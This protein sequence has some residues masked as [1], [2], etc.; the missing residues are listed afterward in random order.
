MAEEA[1]AFK[2]TAGKLS[3]VLERFEDA[4]VHIPLYHVKTQPAEIV[5][6]KINLNG[7]W[8]RHHYL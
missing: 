2:N 3:G 5:D 1:I 8:V 7:K 4:L 6:Y